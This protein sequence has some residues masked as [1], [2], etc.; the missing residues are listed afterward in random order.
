MTRDK[1]QL[2]D[3]ILANW[4]PKFQAFQ[5]EHGQAI[6]EAARAFSVRLEAV[7]KAIR[8]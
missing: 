8:G 4:E 7:S 1:K 5:A 3:E 2:A 6:E